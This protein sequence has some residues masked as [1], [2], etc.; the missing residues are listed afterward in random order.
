M[1]EISII[2]KKELRR[3]FQD[4]KLIFS[5][6][7]LPV[8]LVVGIY[9]LM[10]FMM[11][12]ANDDIAEHVSEVYIMNIPEDFKELITNN[13]YAG[14]VNI[15]QS[16]SELDSIKDDILNG[17]VDLLIV[18]GENFSEDVNAYEDVKA[19]DVKTYYNPSEDYSAAARSNYLTLLEQYRM[20]LLQD[21]VGDLEL[22]K[23]FTVDAANED[24]VIQDDDKAAG[25]LLGVMLPY[26]IT[27]MLFAGAMSI[28]T[29]MITG[30]KER[31]TMA[32]MLLTPI[33][34]MN[35]VLGKIIAMAIISII[36]ALMYMVSMIIA[37]PFMSTQ[38]TEILT[39]IRLLP[40]Q[41]VELLAILL[42]AVFLYVAI[43][44]LIAVFSRT[45]KEASTYMSPAYMLVIVIGLL[46]LFQTNEATTPEY[47]IPVYNISI[48][49]KNIFTREITIMQCLIATVST[50]I[51]SFIMV[52]VMTKA[53]NNE[54]TMFNA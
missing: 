18:F 26:M 54:N 5:L 51:Y 14:N 43:V 24:S 27:M 25:K 53:F 38:D 29:D 32:T 11:Q 9:G 15:V 21:R 20:V 13:E 16:E 33:N 12:N 44:A 4:K 17:D 30:E 36:T 6:F 52:V 39:N 8:I 45:T 3:I 49:L 22:V 50:F 1:R 23:V 10:F 35:I 41:Y 47:L 31:G 46:T 34:R 28:G 37:M 40:V 42:S 2:L 19:P 48:A 7:I